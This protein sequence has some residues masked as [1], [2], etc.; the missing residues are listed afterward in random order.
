MP[1]TLILGPANSAKARETLSAYAAAA[2]RGPVLVVP[3]RTD[4]R[5]YARE[6]AEQQAVLGSVVTFSGLVGEIGRRTGYVGRPISS[7][8]RE[9][10]LLD[11][12]AGLHFD[13]LRESAGAPGF[14]LAAA[15]LVAELERSLI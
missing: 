3:T 14:L 13:V 12:L 15:D 1:L 5:H 9:R 6:L 2:P 4:A 10:V 8:A 11:V 7:L